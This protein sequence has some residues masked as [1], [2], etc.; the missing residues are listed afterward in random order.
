M[1]RFFDSEHFVEISMCTWQGNG[2]SPDFSADFYSVG[3]LQYDAEREAYRVDDISCL[4]DAAEDWKKGVGDFR[5]DVS[6]YFQHCDDVPDDESW[7]DAERRMNEDLQNR[8][9]FIDIG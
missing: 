9:V 2:F 3:G 7:E 4:L 8:Y 1:T 6:D 5:V